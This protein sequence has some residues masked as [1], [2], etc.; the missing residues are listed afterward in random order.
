MVQGYAT[1]DILRA[2]GGT[3]VGKTKYTENQLQVLN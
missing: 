3:A 1:G 2:V